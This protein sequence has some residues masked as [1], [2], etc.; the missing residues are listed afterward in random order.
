M[1]IKYENAEDAKL[2][3]MAREDFSSISKSV[4]VELNKGDEQSKKILREL[5]KSVYAGEELM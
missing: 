4:E 3:I 2:L 5:I 1:T